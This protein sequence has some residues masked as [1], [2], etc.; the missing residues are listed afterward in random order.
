MSKSIFFVCFVVMC[1]SVSLSAGAKNSDKLQAMRAIYEENLNKI[2]DDNARM[3][4]ALPKD[5]L[6]ALKALQQ[7]MQG[8]GNLTGWTAVKEEL[9]RFEI[10]RHVSKETLVTT[11]P[12]LRALQMKYQKAARKYSLEK[13]NSI[14][15]L[16]RMYLVSLSGLQKKLTKQGAIDDALA[17]KE[18]TKRVKSSPD[19]TSAEF[20]LAEYQATEELVKTDIAKREIVESDRARSGKDDESPVV[21][22]DRYKIYR[23]RKPPAISGIRFKKLILR[24]TAHVSV[25]R[26]ATINVMLASDDNVA[27]TDSSVGYGS[28]SISRAGSINHYLRVSVRSNSKTYVVENPTVLVQVFAKLAA[29]H[30]GKLRPQ[31]LSIEHINLPML[32]S[33]WVHID[34]APITISKSSHRYISGYSHARYATGR[35]FYGVIVSI[36]D[37]AGDLIAQGASTSKLDNLATAKLIEKNDTKHLED[38]YRSAK[39]AYEMTR[40]A[41]FNSHDDAGLRQ[42]YR[43]AF[44]KLQKAERAYREAT[45]SEPN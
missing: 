41:Y 37:G 45:G 1:I 25:G 26:K 32:T 33:D 28:R 15:S 17:V 34:L 40:A 22:T 6:K 24:P 38:A 13:I 30:S 19:V 29:K 3:T 27:T 39:N 36:F 18:E 2:K 44:D 31:Q 11:P 42:A 14:L 5:Y 7:K 35:D 4:R 43:E 9:S 21:K 12:E 8:K 20:E 16:R 10:D 23:G